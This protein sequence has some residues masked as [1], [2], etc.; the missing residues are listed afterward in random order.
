MWFDILELCWKYGQIFTIGLLEICEMTTVCQILN[1]YTTWN[2]TLSI[3]ITAIQ[4]PMLRMRSGEQERHVNMVY[5]GC[6]NVK[7]VQ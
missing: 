7:Y 4:L 2:T 5:L 6:G 1:I 3:L